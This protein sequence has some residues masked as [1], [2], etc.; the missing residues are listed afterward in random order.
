MPVTVSARSPARPRALGQTAQALACA[1][2]CAVAPGGC[3]GDRPLPLPQAPDLARGDPAP[4]SV[5]SGWTIEAVVARALRDNPD[6]RALRV[7]R[8]VAE[9]SRRQAG[10][11]ADPAVSGAILPLVAGPGT[12]FAWSAALSED[13]RSLVTLRARRAGAKAAALQVD[14]QTLWQEWQTAA[15]ARLL[16]VQLVDGDRALVPQRESVRLL[17]ERS[18]RLQAALA[19]RDVSLTTVAP[20]LAG[21]Q[22]ARTQLYAAERAQIGRRHALNLLLGREADAPLPLSPA[23]AVPAP[24]LARVDTRAALLARRRPDLVAL[25]LGYRAQEAKV[26]LAVLSRFP[27]F[28]LG[29][30]GGSDNSN[31]RNL[32]PQISTTLPIFD[33]GRADLAL[34]RATREQLRAEYQARLDTAYGQLR[35]AVTDLKGAEQA[36]ATVRADLPAAA[37]IRDRAERARAAGEI[38]ELAYVDLAGAYYAKAAEAAALA[39]TVDEQRLAIAALTGD[40]LPTLTSLPDDAS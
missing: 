7:Q 30:T 37:A 29:L 28:N 2:A 32:G 20:D 18:A 36:L 40:G 33:G 4:P 17:T 25:R 1:L 16:V 39:E 34:Q 23:V 5:D 19:R 24:D 31:V 9:A 27:T 35:T 38:D 21:L 3:A 14:A 10:A 6:L 15:Q 22:A 13:L 12:T 11:L 8:Q 26:R